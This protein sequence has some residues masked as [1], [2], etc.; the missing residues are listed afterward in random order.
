MTGVSQQGSVAGR[1]IPRACPV[2]REHSTTP[3]RRLSLLR[4][5]SA[6]VTRRVTEDWG[7]HVSCS[8]PAAQRSPEVSRVPAAVTV[9]VLWHFWEMHRAGAHLAFRAGTSALVLAVAIL[10][11]VLRLHILIDPS[12]GSCPIILTAR[13]VLA[14]KM[15]RMV[16]E[17]FYLR[18]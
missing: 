11:Q 18:F 12:R 16:V 1:S 13:S 10:L 7:S 8:T 14:A 3:H 5:V 6:S 2:P 9:S 4:A 15:G 17:R